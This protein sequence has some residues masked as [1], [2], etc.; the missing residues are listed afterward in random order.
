MRLVAD[1][2]LCVLLLLAFLVGLTGCQ[3][4]SEPPARFSENLGTEPGELLLPYT[5]AID[6]KLLQDPAQFPVATPAAPA[7]AA[8]TG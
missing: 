2:S 8:A 3:T 5:P 4:S 6:H 7:P 1:R